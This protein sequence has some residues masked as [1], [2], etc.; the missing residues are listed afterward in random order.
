[1]ITPEELR[2]RA[3]IVGRLGMD[4]MVKV[5][6]NAANTIEALQGD[7]LDY[8]GAGYLETQLRRRLVNR[9]EVIRGKDKR[10]HD[11][12]AAWKVV[13]VHRYMHEIL[14]VRVHPDDAEELRGALDALWDDG[15]SV[16]VEDVN[17]AD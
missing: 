13:T 12:E 2:E 1:M 17:A 11:L 3:V 14:H 7:D 5:L 10:I 6:N 4:E 16:S 15:V 9:E 8:E